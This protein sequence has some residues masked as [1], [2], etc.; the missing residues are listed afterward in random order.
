MTDLGKLLLALGG[1]IIL[2][3]GVLLLAGRFNLPLGKLPG[4]IVYRG[5]NTVFYF[6]LTTCIVISI[7]LSLLFWLFGRGHR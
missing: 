4:D 3:G 1:M 6:P 5:K 7:V 2:V